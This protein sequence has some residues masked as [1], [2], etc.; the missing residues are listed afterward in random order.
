MKKIVFV[1]LAFVSINA[2]SQRFNGGILAGVT[3]SQV[4]GDSYAGFDKLG[5][6][7]GVFVNTT[8][9][10]NIG[11]Q[12]EIKYTGRGARKK[13][14]EEDPDIYKVS[15]HYIDIPVM[16]NLTVKEKIVTEAGLV[17]GYLFA[18]SGEDNGGKLPAESLAEFNKFDIA[19]LIGFRYK[20]TDNISAG[21]RYSYS[22]RSV[23][24]YANTAANYSWIGNLFGYNI[25]D[26]N[27]YLTFGLYFQFY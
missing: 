14:S 1:L 2:Y 8:L 20:I 15:L 5:L 22:L 12:I 25:G 18:A 26:Y 27:N 3:A 9:V 13:T 21:M 24:D 4:D 6:L 17:T 7:G 11:A 23:R 16:L 19:W 10:N